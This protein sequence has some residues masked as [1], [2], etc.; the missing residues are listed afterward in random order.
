MTFK[1][2]FAVVDLSCLKKSKVFPKPD[3]TPSAWTF[4]MYNDLYA[5]EQANVLNVGESPTRIEV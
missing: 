3:V 4:D 1:T 5:I 2:A